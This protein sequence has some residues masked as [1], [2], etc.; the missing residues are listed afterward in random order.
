MLIS[1]DRHRL[2]QLGHPCS[3]ETVPHHPR[4]RLYPAQ[5]IA[6]GHVAPFKLAFTECQNSHA[7]HRRRDRRRC[8]GSR[9]GARPSHSYPRGH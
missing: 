6:T 2:R 3:T 5:L 1:I 7:E 4:T 8:A 9:D